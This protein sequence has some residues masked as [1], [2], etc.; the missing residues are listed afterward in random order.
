MGTLR[1]LKR[2]VAS[3]WNALLDAAE[4]PMKLTDELLREMEGE[5][6]RAWATAVQAIAHERLVADAARKRE[7]AARATRDHARADAARK[8]DAAARESLRRARAAEDE[9][10][11][12]AATR[13]RARAAAE[14]V[15]AHVRRLEDGLAAA[16][17][18][19]AAIVARE[20]AAAAAETAAAASAGGRL[21]GGP[22]SAF[23]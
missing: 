14:K 2:I 12:L 1:R 7:E 17:S 18:R 22:D 21:A 11:D 13:D 16:R 15:R 19:R 23:A 4:D 20:R 6:D 5:V 9:A 8:E 3:N 10:R